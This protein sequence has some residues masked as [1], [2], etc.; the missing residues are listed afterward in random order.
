MYTQQHHHGHNVDIIIENSASGIKD[1]FINKEVLKWSIRG[2][3]N[4]MKELA[5]HKKD[6]VLKLTVP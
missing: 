5:I 1:L 4:E 3:M 2:L 6:E